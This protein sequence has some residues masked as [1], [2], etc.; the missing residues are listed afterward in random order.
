[1]W[2]WPKSW[3]QSALQHGGSHRVVCGRQRGHGRSGEPQDMLQPHLLPSLC[4]TWMKFPFFIMFSVA[5]GPS[6]R[7]L[8]YSWILYSQLFIFA[9]AQCCL[10]NTTSTTSPLEFP[11]GGRHGNKP[12]GWLTNDHGTAISWLAQFSGGL[13][14]GLPAGLSG[15]YP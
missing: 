9:V 14:L 4:P 6:C 2:F 7:Y 1:M 12:W 13:I 3:G 8:S 10:K 5:L 15:V 11:S